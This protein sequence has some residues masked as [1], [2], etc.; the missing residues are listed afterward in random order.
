MDV[1]MEVYTPY[2]ELIGVLEI[3]RCVIWEQRAFSAG[4]FSLESL[5]TE[6]SNAL[7]VPENILWISGDYAGVIEHVQQ[8]AGENGPYI[9]VKGRDLTGLL[10]RNILWGRYALS[11]TVAEVM[12]QLVDD[13]CIHPTRGDTEARKIPGL[14]L[15]EADGMQGASILAQKTGGTLLEAL[16]ELGEAYGVAFGVRFNPQVPQMEFWTR[17]GENRS[18]GQSVNE[19]V[20]YSTELDDVLSSEYTYDSGNYRSVALVAGEG[21][22]NERVMVTVNAEGEAEELNL[23]DF[24]PNGE[25]VVMRTSDGQKFTIFASVGNGDS[26]VSAYTGPQI[27]DAIG[28]ALSGGG[29]TS[30]VISFNGRTGPVTPQAEDYT[31]AMVGAATM[32]QVNTAIQMAILDSWEAL[33]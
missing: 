3:Q 24:I 27:D 12:R 33:Y 1:K 10:D 28:K 17:P 26:Y 31:A 9:T 13:C 22:G 16:E 14:V 21:E 18:V 4:S 7:L 6:D 30:G 15:A 19:P 20:F 2:L 23:V 11:G 32:A 29:G 25:T 8:Q 5:I